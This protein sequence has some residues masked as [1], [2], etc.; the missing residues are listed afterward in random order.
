MDAL[1]QHLLKDFTDGVAELKR[2]IGYNPSYFLGMVVEHGPAEA[3]RRLIRSKE[4]SEGFSRLWETN[5]LHM[6]AEA[7]A[8]LPWYEQLFDDQD[9]QLA[10]RRLEAYGFD[11][12]RFLAAKSQSPPAWWDD[13]SHG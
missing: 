7:V 4:V 8:L 5:R 1:E 3:S 12:D 6:T 13:G 2:D 11:V 9:R 10:R